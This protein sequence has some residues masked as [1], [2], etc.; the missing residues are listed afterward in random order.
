MWDSNI[1]F[2]NWFELYNLCN[3]TETLPSGLHVTLCYQ[4]EFQE[5]ELE[6]FSEVVAENQDYSDL[7]DP[8]IEALDEF[9]K[10]LRENKPNCWFPNNER[11][12]LTKEH[13]ETFIKEYKPSDWAKRE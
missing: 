5:V 3:D 7:P 10:V 13:D 2:F 1:Y 8:V 12:V 6:I 9:N 4:T 11:V